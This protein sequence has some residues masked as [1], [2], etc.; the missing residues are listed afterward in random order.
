MKSMMASLALLALVLSGCSDDAGEKQVCGNSKLEAPEACD[1]GNVL[2]GDGCD[3]SCVVEFC[4]DSVVNNTT[5]GCDDGNTTAGD[6]C[7]AS[8]VVEFCG[9]GTTNNTNEACD[10]GNT[11][12]GDGCNAS[13]VDEFCG[14]GVTND[15][16]ETCDDTNTTEGDGCDSTCLLTGCGSGVKTPGEL[17]Y[18]E[19]T[20]LTLGESP[21]GVVLAD[22]NGDEH[23]D[24]AVSSGRTK[25]Y[26]LFGDGTGALTPQPELTAAANFTS[27]IESADFNEDGHPDLVVASSDTSNPGKISVFL[28]SGTGT[29]TGPVSYDTQVFTRGFVIADLDGDDNLDIVVG[30]QNSSTIQRF[31]G[32]GLGAFTAAPNIALASPVSLIGGDFN[33]D[34]AI[35]LIVRQLGIF[36]FKILLNRNDDSGDFADPV[37]VPLDGAVGDIRAFDFDADGFLDLAVNVGGNP[38]RV[39]LFKGNGAAAFTA[40]GSF[41][42]AKDS[43]VLA[44]EDLDGDGKVELIQLEYTAA[45]FYIFAGQGG[46]AFGDALIFPATFPASF[47]IG[48]LN[49]DGLQDLVLANQGGTLRV[50]LFNP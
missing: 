13:C 34:G 42:V 46:F 20:A 5:E 16:T 26:V 45:S 2:A 29:F 14:D 7:S 11:T 43:T 15:T 31:F 4:G 38:N 22:F 35:D 37:S 24:A 47:D 27:D 1:D 12:A 44:I 33:E 32:D 17:C 39:V 25:V 8:C 21:Q 50:S 30:T 9:D 3:T 48:D 19:V 28:N 41:P 23:L 18:D 6:G 10:D 49:E 40:M 36:D